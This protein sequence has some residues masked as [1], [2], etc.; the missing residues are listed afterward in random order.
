MP[1]TFENTHPTTERNV[2]L[3]AQLFDQASEAVLDIQDNPGF[4]S[5]L[6]AHDVAYD[7]TQE[8]FW[9][10]VQIVSRVFY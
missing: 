1:T 7:D 6:K 5:Y 3:P 10:A 9:E 2:D 4:M 8:E